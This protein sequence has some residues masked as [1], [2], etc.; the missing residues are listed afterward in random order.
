LV[1]DRGIIEDAELGAVEA[2]AL[3]R[4]EGRPLL[5]RLALMRLAL[6][7]AL[8]GRIN[9]VAKLLE[10]IDAFGPTPGVFVVDLAEVRAWASAASGD[11]SAARQILEE[12]VEAGE[13]IGDLV[14]EALALHTIA[15]FGAPSDAIDR[16]TDVATRIEGPLAAGRLAHVRGL[17]DRDAPGLERASSA[18]E[19]M[20][21]TLLAAEAA[22][23]AA[24]IFRRAGNLRRASAAELRASILR[25]RCGPVRTPALASISSRA[26]L[27]P[28][29]YDTALLAAA[30]RS[31][32]EIAD[33]LVLSVR[34]V[35]NRLQRVYEKL[36]VEGRMKLVEALGS[37]D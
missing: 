8:V 32:R 21:A 28:A 3:F 37:N 9:D 12:A 30:G 11:L 34:T 22:A 26:R 35:E 36:G 20:G 10:T 14:G 2:G 1:A 6:T 23:D 4:E 18:F 17:V 7:Y 29:E 5:E 33:E 25:D 15:R 13:A 31:N 16:L 27:T 19:P 24:V